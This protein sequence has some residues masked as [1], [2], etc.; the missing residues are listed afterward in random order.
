MSKRFLG[1]LVLMGLMICEAAV[2]QGLEGLTRLGTGRTQRVSSYCTEPDI[3]GNEDWKE[4]GARET[5]TL[6]EVKGPG[7]IR[8]MWFTMNCPDPGFGRAL[9]LRI[10]WDGAKDP[11]VESPLGDFFAVGHGLRREVGSLPVQV[12]SRGRALNCFWQMPFRKSAKITLSNDGTEPVKKAYFYVDYDEVET[13]PKD[14]AYFYAQYRQEFPC[15]TGDYLILDAEGRGH[16]VGTVLSVMNTRK[17]WFGEGDDRFYIDGAKVPTLHGTGTE[18]YFCEAWGFRE[19][20]HPYYGVTV[21]EGNEAGS[22]CTA[23]RWHVAD[24]IRFEKRLRFVIEHKGNRY[25]RQGE[26]IGWGE[27]KDFFASVAFW[28]QTGQAKRYAEVPDWAERMPKTVSV[29]GKGVDGE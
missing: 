8:H 24:P 28:Y 2:A 21:S 5:L 29:R 12:S 17:G 23:Y 10:Y 19:F 26:R 25:D 20:T 7:V 18:D 11:A 13:L 15:E 6:A 4:I 16:Y 1:T 9:V 14:T 27:R 22:Q 3:Q